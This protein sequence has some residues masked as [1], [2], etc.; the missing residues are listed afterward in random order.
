MTGR[1]DIL[2]GSR[3][4]L[5]PVWKAF[6][7]APQTKG[8]EHSAYTVLVDGAGRQRIGFPASELTS[9]ALAAD[10]MRLK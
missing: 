10:L 6:G 5:E 4:Q 1:M 3:S 2:L 9:S 7:I 8:R